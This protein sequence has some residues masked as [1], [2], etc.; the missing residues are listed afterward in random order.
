MFCLG[1][2]C[3]GVGLR[4]EGF[5]KRVWGSEFGAWVSESRV[6]QRQREEEGVHAKNHHHLIRAQ[7]SRF[8]VQCAGRMAGVRGAGFK[9]VWGVQ[10]D[11]L[12][13]GT[14]NPATRKWAANA[15]SPGSPGRDVFRSSSSRE[16]SKAATA[17]KSCC[18]GKLDLC[19]IGVGRQNQELCLKRPF[20]P[21]FSTFGLL[22]SPVFLSFNPH[23]RGAAQVAHVQQLQR[24][25][26]DELVEA[27]CVRRS[28]KWITHVEPQAIRYLLA[29]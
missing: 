26:A 6:Y 7:G 1:S 16:R 10:G 17:Q 12:P 13:L 9:A 22:A 11:G 23:Q 29:S 27:S 28:F 18:C 20:G 8:R 21:A 15:L 3:Q 19:K 14:R 2:R 25:V 5:E 24:Q 4:V